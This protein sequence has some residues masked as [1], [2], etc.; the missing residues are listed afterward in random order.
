[1]SLLAIVALAVGTYALRLIG[2]VF[3]DRLEIPERLQHLLSA[4]AVVLLLA[5]VATGALTDGRSFAGWARP[6]G[7]LVG[8]VLALRRLPFPVVVIAA[9]A[10]T[11]GL[12]LLGVP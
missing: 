2:P 5:L 9:V 6:A 4:A 7:V 10:T 8:A 11:A 1:M 3:R 12:R